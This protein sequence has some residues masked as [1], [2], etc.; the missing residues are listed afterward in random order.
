MN[1]KWE[2]RRIE[3]TDLYRVFCD[4]VEVAAYIPFHSAVVMVEN[5]MYCTGKE[6][7]DE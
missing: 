3:N 4:G 7:T 5:T 2:I 1:D 6:R